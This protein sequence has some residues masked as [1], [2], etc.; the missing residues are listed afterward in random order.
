MLVQM[1]T[2]KRSHSPLPFL[3]VHWGRGKQ[4][5]EGPSASALQNLGSE[6]ESWV[7]DDKPWFAHPPILLT[8]NGGRPPHIILKL[9]NSQL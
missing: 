4:S 2:T 7:L 1:P 5:R 6:A 8:Q 3:K 9:G